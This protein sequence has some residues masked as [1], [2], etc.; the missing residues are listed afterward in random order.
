MSVHVHIEFLHVYMNKF[1]QGKY[2]L[3]GAKIENHYKRMFKY[4]SLFNDES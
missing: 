1:I 3:L 2:G 4:T